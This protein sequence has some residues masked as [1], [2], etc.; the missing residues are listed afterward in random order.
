MESQRCDALASTAEE[1]C[2]RGNVSIL[3]TATLQ[4]EMVVSILSLPAVAGDLTAAMVVWCMGSSHICI[5]VENTCATV[6]SMIG[7]QR[8][9]AGAAATA[10]VRYMD[11][12]HLCFRATSILYILHCYNK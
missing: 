9:A 8:N 3:T 4:S 7:W 2:M 10:V 11:F 12:S 5:D 6:E 1:A